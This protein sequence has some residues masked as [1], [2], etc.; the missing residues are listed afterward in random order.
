MARTPES[1][2][3]ALVKS[4]V[5]RVCTERGLRWVLTWH[6]GD[7]YTSTLDATGVIAGYAVVIEVK[8]FDKKGK[9]TLRQAL[10]L[11]QYKEAGAKSVLLDSH[12]ALA[13]FVRWLYQIDVRPNP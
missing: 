12:A 3:K 4:E 10:L 5:E 2:S 6:A 1:A 8:R 7:I 13:D 11:Q 9:T